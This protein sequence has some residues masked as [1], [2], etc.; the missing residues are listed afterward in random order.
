MAPPI[1]SNFPDWKRIGKRIGKKLRDVLD[2]NPPS[3][4]SPEEQKAQRLSDSFKG[5]VYFDDFDEVTQ[6]DPAGLDPIQSANQPLLPRAADGVHDE[7]G[8]KS[9]ILLCHDYQGGYH[10]YEGV[11]P[12][13]LTAEMYTCDYLQ[14][15]DS[16][17]YFSH[18]LVCVP[19]PTWINLLH[20]NGV[21]VLGTFL[22]EP[23]THHVARLLE[24]SNGHFTMAKQ[25]ADMTS[26]Y[27]FDGWLINIEQDAPDA[28]RD[29]SSELTDF[30]NHLRRDLGEQKSLLW[31]DALTID[32]DVY[33]QNGL[34]PSNVQYAN[35]A[36]ALFTNYKWTEKK[37]TESS[38]MAEKINMPYTDVY[39]GIDVWAQN[40]NMRGRPRVTYPAKDRQKPDRG[41]L[42]SLLGSQ[43]PLP[44]LLSMSTQGWDE[45]GRGPLSRVLFGSLGKDS[46]P[47][48]TIS[49]K[50]L[51][52]Y[53]EEDSQVCGQERTPK[54][55]VLPVIK[56][57][58][59]KLN[60]R[61][62]GSLA[63]EVNFQR[64]QIFNETGCGIYLAYRSTESGHL[65]YVWH[66]LPTGVTN[67]PAT[68]SITVMHKCGP[69]AEL[70]L[71]VT[72]D[73]D[74]SHPIEII[75]ITRIVIKSRE[76][77]TPKYEIRSPQII[78]RRRGSLAQKRISWELGWDDDMPERSV[79]TGIPS[80]NT[81]GP[82]S[83][84]TILINSRS[85]GLAYCNEYTVKPEDT[86]S[87]H[88]LVSI[89]VV[90]SLF[91]GG[92]VR[93]PSV[94]VPVSDFGVG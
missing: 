14:F 45:A 25:L 34:T 79:Q 21:K 37:L 60:M 42:L 67:T 55:D 53:E 93:S 4:P 43:D 89:E 22:I 71:F 38:L 61:A 81:T 88:G 91:G 50:L 49:T 54:I 80:S 36:E 73:L 46:V 40:I 78:E 28:Y 51:G 84:F 7:S 24:R 82:F 90:G 23:Q 83:S 75:E 31:Y 12:D 6:W 15:V 18:K 94:H 11:R 33:Y 92:S 69:L 3:G 17:V 65:K 13:P 8:P 66:E 57:W 27:G 39:F 58:L 48:L 20:R 77:I 56:L 5:F 47:S 26:A 32:G 29:W 44:N 2:P 9:K 19:P 86:Q 41:Y 52:C 10:D 63:A 30:L 62:D 72:R 85:I 70:G 1:A 64:K 74:A 59:Y 68:F 16:F 76:V 87:L 35:A